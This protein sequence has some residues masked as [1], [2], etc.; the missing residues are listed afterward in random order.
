[1]GLFGK[2][3]HEG[4]IQGIQSHL[5]HNAKVLGDPKSDDKLHIKSIQLDLCK[6][7]D[8]YRSKSNKKLDDLKK[9]YKIVFKTTKDGWEFNQPKD[10]AFYRAYLGTNCTKIYFIL[11]HE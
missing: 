6:K 1:M 4:T 7:I 8:H 5:S 10:L 2:S 3:R 9:V 11:I